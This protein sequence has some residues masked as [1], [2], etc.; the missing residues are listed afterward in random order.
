MTDYLILK[1]LRDNPGEW[2]QHATA[3]ASSPAR[4]LRISNLGAGEYVAV[5][6]RNW[7]PLTVKV[8]QKSVVTVG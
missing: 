3:T 2:E 6:V 7:K 4:A 8:E 5:P 1:Q